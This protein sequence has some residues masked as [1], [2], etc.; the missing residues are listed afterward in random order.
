[1]KKF[2]DL[3]ISEIVALTE[4][5]IR[6]YINLAKV[7]A[8]VPLVDLEVEDVELKEVPQPTEVW[9]YTDLFGSSLCVKSKE[10]LEMIAELTKSGELQ[11]LDY[12]YYSNSGSLYYPSHNQDV[13]ELRFSQILA[14]KSLKEALAA[15]YIKDKNEELQ[16]SAKV[17]EQDFSTA[18]EI[19]S[20]IYEHIG[21][22][23]QEVSRAKQLNSIFVSEYLPLVDNDYGKALEFF[24]KA[25]SIT[26][27]VAK[28]L[29]SNNVNDLI[30]PN[31][32]EY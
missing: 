10:T 6:Y 9:Y 11:R 23:N 32:T 4:K 22:V 16:E 28:Y 7:E 26:D 31:E 8:G 12:Y 13:T 20:S 14:Y 27:D 18:R 3:T 2:K 25:Y 17:E 1:M 21:K 5:E 30:I 15:K 24:K 29:M 19:E